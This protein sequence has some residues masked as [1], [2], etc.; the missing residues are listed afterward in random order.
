MDMVLRPRDLENNV[1][2]IT[3]AIVHESE[4]NRNFRRIAPFAMLL[5]LVAL[6]LAPGI[7]A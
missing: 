7:L 1:M 4:A 2:S 6:I 3:A 5:G